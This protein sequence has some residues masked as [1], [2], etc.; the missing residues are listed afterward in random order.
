MI[1]I[2]LIYVNFY[3]LRN[4]SGLLYVSKRHIFFPYSNIQLRIS[5]LTEYM[6][7]WCHFTPCKCNDYIQRN[8]NICSQLPQKGEI[9]SHGSWSENDILFICS[10][11]EN[12]YSSDIISVSSLTYLNF[13]FMSKPCGVKGSL[14]I[15]LLA[16]PPLSPIYIQ[17]YGKWNSLY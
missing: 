3:L 13:K 16:I 1:V 5:V 7:H 10:K 4:V 12:T 11:Q 2:M 14:C 15:A 9:L 8:L 17:I 6:L